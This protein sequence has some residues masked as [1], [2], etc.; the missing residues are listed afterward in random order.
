MYRKSGLEASLTPR[1]SIQVVKYPVGFLP[2]VFPQ[3]SRR[4]RK[5]LAEVGAGGEVH[6]GGD[7]L[8]ALRHYRAFV[9]QVAYFAA[10]VTGGTFQ[11]INRR[12]DS[13]AVLNVR[14]RR[15]LTETLRASYVAHPTPPARWRSSPRFIQSPLSSVSIPSYKGSSSESTSRIDQRGAFSTASLSL[16]ASFARAQGDDSCRLFIIVSMSI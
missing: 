3:Q 15:T 6:L 14:P 4:P 8:Y 7:V 5:H 9:R 10:Y 11:G 12:L 13:F 1:S 16:S 2:V